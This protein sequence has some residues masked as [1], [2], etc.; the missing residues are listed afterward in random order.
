MSVY[1]TIGPLVFFFFVGGGGGE[2]VKNT[3]LP[4]TLKSLLEISVRENVYP[5]GQ[6]TWFF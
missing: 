6:P 1:R 4:K 5:L 2:G 3:F